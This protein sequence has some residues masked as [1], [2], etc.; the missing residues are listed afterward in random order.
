MVECDQCG[1]DKHSYHGKKWKL[2]QGIE[3]KIPDKWTCPKCGHV[4]EYQF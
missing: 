2:R 3:G 1:F 4:T